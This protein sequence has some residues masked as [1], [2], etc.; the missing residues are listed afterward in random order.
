MGLLINDRKLKAATGSMH[1]F[2]QPV[3]EIFPGEVDD[4]VVESVTLYLYTSLTRDLFGARFGNKLQKRLLPRLKYTTSAEVQGHMARITKHSSALEKVEESTG[5][6]RSPDEAV[7]A[8][9]ASTIEAFLSDAGFATSDQAV[10]QKAYDR[11][12]RCIKVMREHLIGIR[13]QN[14]FLM[15]TRNVA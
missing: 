3:R 2:C 14:Y 9:V 10:L 6:T 12:E 13:E 1:Q 8:H 11:F 7:R 5:Q 4:R 15:K